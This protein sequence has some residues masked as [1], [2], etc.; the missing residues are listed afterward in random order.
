MN[1][2]Q[3]TGGAATPISRIRGPL[4]SREGGVVP[5]SSRVHRH[6]MRFISMASGL[7]VLLASSLPALAAYPEKPIR[8]IVPAAAGGGADAAVRIVANELGRRLGQSIVVDNRPGASGA[9]GLEAV[10]KAAP[11]GYTI[12][13]ANISNIVLNRQVRS[14][15][16]FDPDKDLVPVAKISTQPN[17]LV[18]NPRLPVKNVKELVAYAKSH[19]NALFYGSS[20][21]GS[22]L[23]VA[24]EALRQA[25][26]MPMVHVPYKSAPA[27]GL[28]LV[29]NNTQVMIDNLSTLAP[30]IRNGKVRAL[31]VTSENRS[32]SLPQ[33]PTIAESGVPSFE[34]TVWGGVVA[35]NGLSPAVLKRLSDEIIA[36]L[37]TP[38]IRKR[39]ADL[40]YEPDGQGPDKLADLIRRENQK[41]GAIVRQAHIT[42]E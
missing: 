42:A 5:S 10:A 3:L 6:W 27:A 40:G 16:P 22:S 33:V 35:P 8:W 15:L 9:I 21:S 1:L 25:T 2:N 26:G 29:A 24:M 39:L 17:V 41:W 12:G 18:V 38:E 32:A 28:D 13:T 31:A 36:V 7:A 34:M 37:N 4:L 20:G 14:R 23:H 11:D 30:F 19:P